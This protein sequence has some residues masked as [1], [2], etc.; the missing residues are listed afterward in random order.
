MRGYWLVSTTR[1]VL[2]LSAVCATMFGCALNPMNGFLDPTKVGRFPPEYKEGG[3]R[4][5]LTPRESP[6]GLANA[7][8]PTADDLT[9][10]FEEYRLG[11]ADQLALS[12]DDFLQAGLPFT[13]AQEVTTAGYIRIPQLGLIKVTGMT[14]DE[15]EE[16][17][18]TRVR[19][20]K[21][22][23][24]PVV[25]VQITLKRQQTFSILG[26]IRTPGTYP[27]PNNDLR[28]LE[29]IGMA[30]DMG[31]T[32]R[33]LY[34]IRRPENAP[35]VPAGTEPTGSQPKSDLVIPP[36]EEIESLRGVSM[37]AGGSAVVAA[38]ESA[39]NELDSALRPAEKSSAAQ[40]SQPGDRPFA[41]LVFDPA[42]GE[43]REAPATQETSTAPSGTPFQEP[44]SNKEFRWEEEPQLGESQRVI[45]INADALRAG[46]PK[47]N[48]IVRNRDSIVIPIDT[49]LFYVMGEVNRPGAFPL[50]DRE[51]TLKQAVAVFGGFSAMAWPARC[52]IIR[53]EK[54][55]DKQI[56]IPINLDAIFAG[57]E[58]D[59]L[60]KD[61]DIVNV[62]SNIAAPFLFV[63]RNSFR[64][65][66]GFGFVYDRN[67]AD[68][69]AYG[70]KTNPEVLRQI[71][72][73]NRGLPF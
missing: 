28:L 44:S 38:Q 57:I 58:D 9:P 69:D 42:T 3:I 30:G 10:R 14:E 45:E 43:L 47:Q 64:F 56:T 46:E 2:L 72:R 33:R 59:V 19:Q 68:Q 18:R 55:T 29:A 1:G 27:L 51:I 16:D 66:Y 32:V 15:L 4:R 20:A 50:S 13:A 24:D 73:Q 12:I 41:P 61:D 35:E 17:I 52:E 53:R 49:G 31:A 37:S 26:A 40:A 65:T 5:V 71:R 62:G 23:P 7:I 60:L 54:G 21:I 8:E 63:I 22:L 39:Q 11:P 67:F 36:P 25:Q 34:V 70:A 6:Y 48:I